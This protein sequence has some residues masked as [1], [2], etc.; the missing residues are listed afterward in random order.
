MISLCDVP[1]ALRSG[2]RLLLVS[3]AA[4]VLAALLV[5]PVHAAGWSASTTGN[6][7]SGVP[8]GYSYLAWDGQASNSWGTTQ[9][10]LYFWNG[11]AW[12]M[13][14]TG[15]DTRYGSD[16]SAIKY[17]VGNYAAGWWQQAATHSSSFFS[18]GHST[19]SPMYQ[20]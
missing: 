13:Q 20:C 19:W 3:V 14:A 10:T 6:C 15:Q 18:G 5:V 8:D 1:R 9:A 12:V 16:N 17:N 4:A 11:G 7:N 2:W